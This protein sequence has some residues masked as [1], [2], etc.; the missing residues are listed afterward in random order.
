VHLVLENDRNQARYLPRDEAGAA[1]LASA[2]WNDDLHHAAHVIVTGERDGYYADYA[3]APLRQFGRAL[4]EGFA[5][6]GGPSAYRGGEARGEPCAHLPPAAFVDFLQTHDQIGNRAFGERIAQLAQPAPLRAVLACVLLA[7]AVPLLFMGEEFAASAPFLYFCDFHGELARAVTQGRR[8]E[9]A[10]FQRF[11]DPQ[12]REGIPDPNHAASFERSKLDW[13]ERT[14]GEHARWLAF[15]RELLR[16]RREQLAPH[17][18]DA[19]SG[20][21]EVQ[22]GRLEVH[23]PLGAG[24]RQLHLLANLSDTPARS[25]RQPAGSTLYESHPCGDALPPWFVRVSLEAPDE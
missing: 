9:F 14:R 2:Q 22:A 4:A 20:R 3:D 21:F 1:R 6:Q 25:G 10:R 18:A 19:R 16:L 5:F 15:Y 11:A 17:L 7:P 24:R 12:L 13:D 8:A 23:W